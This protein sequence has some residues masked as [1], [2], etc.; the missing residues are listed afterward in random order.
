MCYSFIIGTVSVYQLCIFTWRCLLVSLYRNME[1]SGFW[2]Y[3]ER[4]GKHIYFLWSNRI[5]K[6][7]Y[8]LF[9][10]SEKILV[11]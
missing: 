6:A 1:G 7:G 10:E 11:L 3:T 5:S 2:L 4:Q 9:T 8:T